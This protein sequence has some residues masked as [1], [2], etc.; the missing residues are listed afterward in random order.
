MAQA[1]VVTIGAMAPVAACLPTAFPCPK[2]PK[3]SAAPRRARSEM[4]GDA[5]A[6][7]AVLAED[8]RGVRVQWNV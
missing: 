8:L 4:P 7:A 2:P 5:D 3:S 6:R 1:D